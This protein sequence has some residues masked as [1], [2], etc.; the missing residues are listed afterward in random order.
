MHYSEYNKG[1]G[2]GREAR[3]AVFYPSANISKLGPSEKDSGR[4][5]LISTRAWR[6]HYVWLAQDPKGEK[7]ASKHRTPFA[8]NYKAQNVLYIVKYFL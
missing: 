8:L 7:I 2:L 4:M 3:R 6:R 1:T 5:K